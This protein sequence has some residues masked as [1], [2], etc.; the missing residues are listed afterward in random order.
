MTVIAQRNGAGDFRVQ[1]VLQRTFTPEIEIEIA[2]APMGEIQSTRDVIMISACPTQNEAIGARD[3]LA[4]DVRV[5]SLAK[6]RFGP[7]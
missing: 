6:V 2:M 4:V 7:T 1:P 3:Q 5:V